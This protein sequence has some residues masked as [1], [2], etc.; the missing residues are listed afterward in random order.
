VAC[1]AFAAVLLMQLLAPFAR[2]RERLFGVAPS[3]VAAS[4]AWNPGDAPA[5][6]GR[7]GLLTWRRGL[8]ALVAVELV[9]LFGGYQYLQS[10]STTADD[11]LTITEALHAS[12]CGSGPLAIDTF[13]GE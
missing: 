11:N 13:W 9:F 2:L 8:L 10:G 5:A 7:S 3:H 6:A 12:W 4:V 1:C